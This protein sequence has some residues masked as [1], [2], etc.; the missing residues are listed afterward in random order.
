MKFSVL[1]SVYKNEKPEFFK[2]AVNSVIEQTL[3]PEE[4]ILIRD[5]VVP[6]E[7]QMA[8]DEYLSNYPQL[9]TYIPLEE[10]KGLGNALMVGVEKARNELIARMD[11]DD[12]SVPNRFEKQIRFMQENPEIDVL[13]SLPALVVI[14]IIAFSKLTC[15]P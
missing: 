7:L 12:I 6:A 14:I 8:I 4:I 9:F 5:G 13:F 3:A 1:M 10:N 2:Q 15:L 11:T